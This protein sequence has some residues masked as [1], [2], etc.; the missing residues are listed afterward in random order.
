MIRGDE[1]HSGNDA[2]NSSVATGVEYANGYE[3]NILRY[4]VCGTTNRSDD[5]RSVSVTVVRAQTIVDGRET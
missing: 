2:G 4:A 1:I 3:R 5:V